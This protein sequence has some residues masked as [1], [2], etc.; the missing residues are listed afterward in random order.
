MR[1]D[2]L[3]VCIRRDIVCDITHNGE[4]G[5]STVYYPVHQ[6]ISTWIPRWLPLKCGQ[7]DILSGVVFGHMSGGS[8]HFLF[9][10]YMPYACATGRSEGGMVVQPFK[11]TFC[12]YHKCSRFYQ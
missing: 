7:R 6:Y 10:F 8:S 12:L 11:R 1:C 9:V 2:L 5:I 4:P 3:Y